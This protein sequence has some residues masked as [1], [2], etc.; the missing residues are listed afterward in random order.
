M[1]V[2]LSWSNGAITVAG[3]NHNAGFGQ[4][5]G[6]AMYRVRLTAIVI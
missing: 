4:S 3:D 6:M 5:L 2:A 1:T